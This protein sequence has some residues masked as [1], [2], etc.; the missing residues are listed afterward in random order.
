[1]LIQ[2]D[3]FLAKILAINPEILETRK[4]SKSRQLDSGLKFWLRIQLPGFEIQAA[5]F[6]AKILAPNPAAWI[7]FFFRISKISLF[8]AFFRLI[9]L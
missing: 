4:S 8:F 6:E 2:A 1:M 3:G 7:C 5:G 9:F